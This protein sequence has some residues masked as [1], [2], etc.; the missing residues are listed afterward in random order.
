[1]VNGNFSDVATELTN[2]VAKDGQSTL[3]GV[4]KLFSGTVSAPGLI[5]GADTTTGWY[6]I[7]ANN[8][9]LSISGTKLLDCSAAA[10]AVTGTLT[11]SSTVTASDGFTLSSGTLSLPA[12]SI[13]TADLASN[14][15]TTVKITDANITYAKIQNVSAENKLLGR[16]TAGAGVVEEIGLAS[17]VVLSGGN[18]SIG[19]NPSHVLLS[20]TTVSGA[21]S[22]TITA[23]ID[24]TYDEYELHISNLQVA[25]DGVLV[26][27]Q[28][29][30]DGGS[31]YESTSYLSTT[32]TWNTADG[33]D[34]DQDT[35]GIQLVSSAG[36]QTMDNST[37]YAWRGLIRFWPNG[38]SS[39]KN[40]NVDGSYQSNGN[41]FVI[42]KGGGVWNG[43]NTAINAIRLIASS[44]N[45][46]AT[47]RLVGI[48]NSV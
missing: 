47:A 32:F 43:G 41:G 20:T 16:S 35:A 33:T 15:V 3:T 5:F 23:D 28:V 18:L 34:L 45:I 6:R 13:E 26:R 1:M 17:P 24:S 31:N 21:A 7:G 25:T 46:T 2:S 11:V 14:A 12:G 27:L 38:S 22:L 4:L 44:G 29:S 36:N 42:V 19:G 10:L 40:F 30:T 37:S 48:K 9:G 39:R 8:Y